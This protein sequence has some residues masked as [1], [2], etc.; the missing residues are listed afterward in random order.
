MDDVLKSKRSRLYSCF[1]DFQKPFDNVWH[2]ALMLKIYKAGIKGNC[3]KVIQDMY[4]NAMICT[5]APGGYSPEIPVRRGVHQGNC[6]SPTLF[7]V[8]INDLPQYLQDNDS[9]A[10]DEHKNI[11]ISRLLYAD[12][13]VILS[14]SKTGLQ[15]KLNKLNQFCTDW[16]L[17]INREK[18]KIVIFTH[19]EPKAS[20]FFV[21]GDNIIETVDHY[22]YLG[23]IFQKNGKFTLAQEHLAKQ[24]NKA[25]H[26]LR[27]AFRGQEM[28]V[29]IM[30]QLYDKLV[31]P[32]SIYGAEIWFPSNVKIPDESQ[33]SPL[34]DFF[35]SCLSQKF[36]HEKI[37]TRFCK[38]LLGLHC[39]AMNLP[40]L[41]ELGRFPISIRIVC[42]IIGFWI[43]ITE[44]KDNSYTKDVY[45]QA[46]NQQ[47]NY[48]VLWHKFVKYM[49]VS[50]GMRHTWTNQSTLSEHRLKHAIQ[51]QLE[52]IY[53]QFWIQRKSKYASRLQFYNRITNNNAYRLEPYL[54]STKVKL[55]KQA[56]CKLRVSA[57][58]L[59][60]ERGRHTNTPREDRKCT[61]CGVVED[62]IHFLDNCSKFHEQ[63]RKFIDLANMHVDNKINSHIVKPS[64][65]LHTYDLQQHLAKYV[66]DCFNF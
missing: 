6:L 66:F 59:H 4:S 22:K 32:I 28:N 56:L 55:Y 34:F 3:F 13:L 26:A 23:I 21:C 50:L 31:A 47:S 62:E 5:R 12:D 11:H 15:N 45:D 25:A 57:H 42:Q 53:K 9:P 48:G 54:I 64:D 17:K 16:G 7:N 35:D 8:F 29:K 61:V 51:K 18:T 30:L 2:D 24:A 20:I 46:L 43:H 63:R 65:A 41:A 44:V 1:V 39:K 27:K 60:I 38:R 33:T 40:T 52:H 58:N 37:H 49:L 36:P 10:L 14:T 19:T